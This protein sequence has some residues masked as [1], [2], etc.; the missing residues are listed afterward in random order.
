MQSL[1]V[2]H[3]KDSGDDKSIEAVSLRLNGLERHELK[4][5]PWSAYS[6]KPAVYFSIAHNNRDIFLKYYVTET[7]IRANTSAINGSVWEDSC[8]EFF[9][10]FDDK[11]YYNLEINCIGTA[12][13]GFGPERSGRVLLAE[14]LIKKIRFE[15]S[16]KNNADQFQWELV[17]IIPSEIFLHHSFSSLKDITARANFYKCGDALPRPHFISWAPIEAQSP[18]F[19]LP[20]F[21]GMLVFE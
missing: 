14:Q 5:V 2:T 9:I 8:V 11:G 21:F 18:N 19:H 13:V 3:L 15:T 16:I 17:L 1:H 12:L 10:S 7:D 6:Y 4:M 20:Q